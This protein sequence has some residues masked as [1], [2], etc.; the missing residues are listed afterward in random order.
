MNRSLLLLGAEGEQACATRIGVARMMVGSSALV[1]PG[2]AGAVFG[3]PRAQD[4]PAT[5]FFARA[6]GIRN[7]VLGLWALHSRNA[8]LGA[9]RYCYTANLAVDAVDV[10]ALIWPIARRQRLDR[11]ALTSLTLGVSAALAWA[12]LLR[13]ADAR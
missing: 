13:L 11:F 4:V 9:R 7:I 1:V 8:D 3:L 12:D 6:F 5:R 10:V 2:L